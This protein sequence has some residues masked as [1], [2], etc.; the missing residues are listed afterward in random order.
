M[1][2]I[3]LTDAN[4]T[5]TQ[6]D[7]LMFLGGRQSIAATVATP[8]PA[9]LRTVEGYAIDNLNVLGRTS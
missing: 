4:G 1:A 8:I 2:K 3:K 6:W 5:V 7:D 9:K